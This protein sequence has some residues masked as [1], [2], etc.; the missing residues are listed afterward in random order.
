MCV[1]NLAG[2]LFLVP[3]LLIALIGCGKKAP[4]TLPKKSS[5]LIG[6]EQNKAISYKFKPAKVLKFI[7]CEFKSLGI[8]E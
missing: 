6:I 3:L 2:F 7:D 1:K 5:S 8:E 4:P